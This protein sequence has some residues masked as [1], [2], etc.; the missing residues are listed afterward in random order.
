MPLQRV[1]SWA[2]RIESRWDP[3]CTELA[4]IVATGTGPR[5]YAA[6]PLNDFDDILQTA[7]QPSQQQW[8]RLFGQN[9]GFVKC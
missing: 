4:Y 5:I 2:L 1:A 9:F 6:E 7:D 3:E 8:L